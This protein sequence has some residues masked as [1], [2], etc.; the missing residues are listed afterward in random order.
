MA[1]ARHWYPLETG[2]VLVGYWVRSGSEVVITDSIGPGPAAEHGESEFK[3]DALY[4]QEQVARIYRSSGRLYTYLGDWHSH[5][6]SSAQL[7]RVDKRT[8][9]LIAVSRSARAPMPIMAV[10]T[11]RRQWH[12]T[13]W[14]ARAR[15][16]FRTVALSRLHIK[17][18]SADPIREITVSGRAEDL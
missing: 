1:Q 7:S 16:L 14:Y 10:A 5:P 2:G 18:F 13:L 11:K 12:L 6:R 3:P 8:L 17:A 9:Y 15:K 4:Q